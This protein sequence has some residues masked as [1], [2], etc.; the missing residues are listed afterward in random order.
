MIEI[1]SRL[2]CDFRSSGKTDQ[3]AR[4]SET[5]SKSREE[6]AAVGSRRSKEQ[7]RERYMASKGKDPGA[8]TSLY[9][10]GSGSGGDEDSEDEL[11][12]LGD[13][14]KR[15]AVHKARQLKGQLADV[16]RSIGG[17]VG[18]FMLRCEYVTVCE[19]VIV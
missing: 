1:T 6:D 5:K 14:F 4:Q 9:D 10:A 7:D 13:Q 19:I 15:K 18:G 11:E 12:A 3:R 17:E 2:I 8:E 16:G